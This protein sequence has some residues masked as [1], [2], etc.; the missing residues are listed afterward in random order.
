VA[1]PITDFE[2]LVRQLQEKGIRQ[3]TIA[4]KVATVTTA[5][6]EKVTFR[7][8]LVVT[9]DL[10]PQGKLEYVEQVPAYATTLEVPSLPI[11]PAVEP[12]LRQAQVALMSQLHA[13]REQYQSRMAAARS[14]LCSR[15]QAGGISVISEQ[16]QG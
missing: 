5:G 6:G 12:Q 10:G 13:Y 4:G 3:V 8:R 15:L 16:G 1:E 11:S 2:S 7:G 14:D 9:A